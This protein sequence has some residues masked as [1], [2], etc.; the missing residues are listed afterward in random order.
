MSIQRILVADD[1]ESIR[2]VL[3]KALTKQGFTVDLAAD[4]AEAKALFQ[5]R[6]YDL[7]ILD[8]KMPDISGLELLTLFPVKS[9]RRCWSSSSPPN[10]P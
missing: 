5:R 9:S 3:R 7:A 6:R 10:P 8:I 1:E 2:W 4:G